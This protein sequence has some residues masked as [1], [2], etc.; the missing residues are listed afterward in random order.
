M[1]GLALTPTGGT[2]NKPYAVIRRWVAPR[3]GVISIEGTLAHPAK[4]G[5]G[6]QGRIVSNR[7][8]E[9]GTWIAFGNQAATALPRLAV[10]KDETIDFVVDCRENPRNDNY[11]WA[12]VIKM[13]PAANQKPE[14]IDA[15]NA[16]KD[17]TGDI[18]A[19]R[20]SPWEKFA[21]VLLETNEL[22]FVN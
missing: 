9:L 22:T 21:Q 19:R 10:K 7:S 1:K 2:P 8:G 14:A 20:L 18:R 6:V 16:Q 11:N 17:F 15:W 13:E 12:P 3:D 4:D 5:D